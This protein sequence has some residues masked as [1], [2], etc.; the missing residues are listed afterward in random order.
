M[1][2]LFL[3]TPWCNTLFI[4]GRHDKLDRARSQHDSIVKCHVWR[5]ARLAGKLIATDW[6]CWVLAKSD[7]DARRQPNSRSALLKGG[8]TSFAVAAPLCTVCVFLV[9]FSA[10]YMFRRAD[11]SIGLALRHRDN[12]I[13]NYKLVCP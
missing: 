13:C 7:N 8:E 3:V 4:E 10:R 6:R 12:I 5:G 11:T 2:D 1:R 9:C